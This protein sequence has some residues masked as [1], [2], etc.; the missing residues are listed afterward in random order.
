MK[1]K[2]ICPKCGGRLF[3]TTAHVMEEWLVDEHGNFIET[4]SNCLEVDTDPDDD[5]IWTCARCGADGVII[6]EDD[7][8]R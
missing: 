7:G 4:S 1:S 5:N 8:S 3:Y 6:Q 2:H